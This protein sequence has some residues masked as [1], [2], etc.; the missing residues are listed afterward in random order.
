MIPAADIARMRR[1]I[2]EPTADNYTDDVLSETIER[3]P[4]A[5]VTGEQPLDEDGIANSAWTATYDMNAAAAELWAEKAAT[6]AT[7]FDFSADGASFQR[8]QAAAQARQM[9]AFYRSRR[10][11]RSAR[12][13]AALNPTTSND[14]VGNLA[15]VLS[16]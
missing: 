14:W 5:D 12:L 15:E 1:M 13:A 16:E 4:I 9:A 2:A 11:A 8:S 6:L 7:R 3:Y 10:T